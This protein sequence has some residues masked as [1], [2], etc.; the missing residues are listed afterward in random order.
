MAV[1]C[2]TRVRTDRDQSEP[3]RGVVA[4]GT[5]KPLMSEA[6]RVHREVAQDG[7]LRYELRRTYTVASWWKMKKTNLFA[8]SVLIVL[9]STYAGA[10]GRPLALVEI[11]LSSGTHGYP[12][13]AFI[14]LSNRGS[15]AVHIGG[16]Q[17]G[18]CV[19]GIARDLATIAP[20]TI[21]RPAG[22][23][24]L[25]AER[26]IE[27][28]EG[29]VPVDQRW[30][31]TE[32]IPG[33]ALLATESGQTIAHT[34]KGRDCL[35]NARGPSPGA[36]AQSTGTPDP[37]SA[38]R[39][40]LSP[41]LADQRE[42]DSVPRNMAGC[43]P[44]ANADQAKMWECHTRL[45]LTGDWLKSDLAIVALA[46]LC[47]G[48]SFI[49]L[50]YVLRRVSD[51]VA[52]PNPTVHG[53]APPVQP[54]AVVTCVHG[55]WARGERW[56]IVAQAV[57]RALGPQV[58]FEYFDWPVKG[59]RTRSARNSVYVRAKAASDFVAW[60]DVLLHKYPEADHYIIGHSHG[61]SIVMTGLRGYPHRDRLRGVVCLSTPFVH[62]RVRPGAGAIAST[63]TAGVALVAA[64]AGYVF[65]LP[66]WPTELSATHVLG[67]TPVVVGL[68][69]MTMSY[70]F[71]S[72]RR[73]AHSIQRLARLPR[74]FSECEVLLL[75][76]PADET[77]LG[78]AIAQV[79]TTASRWMFWVLENGMASMAKT[80]RRV[81]SGAVVH[82][83]I[84]LGVVTALFVG[85]SF[86]GNT[87][88][89]AGT[90][91]P[92]KVGV[93]LA[94]VTALVVLAIASVAIAWTLLTPVGALV[95]LWLSGPF[96]L[97]F[98]GLRV[99]LAAPFLQASVEGSP[100][101]QWRV[102]QL[103]AQWGVRGL[104]HSLTHEAPNA[105]SVLEDW[106]R[107]RSTC[108]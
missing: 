91:G 93:G 26:V 46:I 72:L 6:T 77:T 10:Q 12:R 7:V 5:T 47:L 22:H 52:P 67:S 33:G 42:I 17:I 82:L 74:P 98:G 54:K 88:V 78:L 83:L 43:P 69:A 68:G 102:H 34:P 94:I 62:L 38:R 84:S 60:L 39:F 24:L 35:R 107:K 45:A 48:A 76:S 85:V 79:A 31:A 100:P 70:V 2:W 97:P 23:Y 73:M 20:G 90:P 101:G 99:L 1:R 56:P 95:V 8:L 16:W 59:G 19:D 21:L 27:L 106:I 81:R 44:A 18:T 15:D 58:R 25:A 71:C 87:W 104:N 40:W 80:G 14:Q 9:T 30:D 86:I 28:P 96:M 53:P 55:T 61:G 63:A 75:R 89:Q 57:V 37:P 108:P 51:I 4:A 3:L 64:G 36:G 105:A 32:P 66:M 49:F 41:R 65:G 92:F 103:P 11:T 29:K 50:R 13:S